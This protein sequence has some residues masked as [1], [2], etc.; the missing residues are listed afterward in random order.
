MQV[1][2]KNEDERRSSRRTDPVNFVIYTRKVS[3]CVEREYI[4]RFRSRR[5]EI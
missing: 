1:V 4:R 5:I 3:K 2:Y